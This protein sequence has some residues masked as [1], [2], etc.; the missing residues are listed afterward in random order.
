VERTPRA[1]FA[2]LDLDEQLVTF[3]TESY[4]VRACRRLLAEQGLPPEFI[5]L[6]PG[7]TASALRRARHALQGTTIET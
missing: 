6:A 1:R 3:F 4:D 7:R 2:L 5:H